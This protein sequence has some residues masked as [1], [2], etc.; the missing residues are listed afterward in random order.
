MTLV[1]LVLVGGWAVVP[2][3]PGYDAVH[4]PM[5]MDVFASIGK[6]PEVASDTCLPALLFDGFCLGGMLVRLPVRAASGSWGCRSGYP[7]SML[8][9]FSAAF[10]RSAPRRLIGR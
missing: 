3:W 1:F 10:L 7:L 8:F 2:K 6:M 5:A 4:R 9:F